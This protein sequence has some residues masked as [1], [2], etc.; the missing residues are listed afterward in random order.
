MNHGKFHS[1]DE[2]LSALD[3]SWERGSPDEGHL[4]WH[5]DTDDL[6]NIEEILAEVKPKRI[7]ETGFCAGHSAMM[8]LA[9]TDADVVSLDICKLPCTK[10]GRVL[11][12]DEYPDR[13]TF[14]PVD[15]R[16]WADVID[17][18][19]PYAPLDLVLID[20][21]HNPD[22]VNADTVTSLA[23]E[24]P[25]LI[26]DNYE[27][28]AVRD[29]VASYIE[30]GHIEMVKKFDTGCEKTDRQMVWC[31]NLKEWST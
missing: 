17:L 31:K 25:H 28:D 18:L 10:Q 7:L 2:I 14:F 16:Q 30:S 26:Y 4:S 29:C 6:K 21:D 13:F 11:L 19:C 1:V 9:L 20:A 23:L 12:E 15:T 5:T 22:G 24:I 27:T 8:W 3:Y